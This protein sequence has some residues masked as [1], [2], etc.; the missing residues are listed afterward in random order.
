MMMIII[1][2]KIRPV[3][4]E[5]LNACAQADGHDEAKSNFLNCANAPKSA[6][7]RG[8]P[9]QAKEI[10]IINHSSFRRRKYIS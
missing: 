9:L 3:R 1:I 5:F 8:L 10:V 4:A 6:I 2:I 7:V